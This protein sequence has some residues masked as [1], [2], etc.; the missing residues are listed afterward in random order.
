MAPS[1]KP[2][3]PN[4]IEKA[5]DDKVLVASRQEIKKKKDETKLTRDVVERGQEREG[6][7]AKVTD[8]LWLRG[9]R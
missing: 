4:V 7:R 6:A 3:A 5:R 9:R 1:T 8:M 2:W